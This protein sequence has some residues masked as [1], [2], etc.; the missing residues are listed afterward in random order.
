M[1]FVRSFVRSFVCLFVCLFAALLLLL[2]LFVLGRQTI[3][4]GLALGLGL[5]VVGLFVCCALTGEPKPPFLIFQ[6]VCRSAF[7]DVWRM[8]NGEWPCLS[9][10]IC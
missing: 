5:L 3:Y 6:S 2:L 8:E 4:H 10:G 9:V 1:V 7:G